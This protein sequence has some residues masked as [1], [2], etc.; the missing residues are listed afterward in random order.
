M[1]MRLFWWRLLILTHLTSVANA[2][3]RSVSEAFGAHKSR[4]AA[5]GQSVMQP[6]YNSQECGMQYD[7]KLVHN[8]LSAASYDMSYTH[9]WHSG[10][11]T[12]CDTLYRIIWTKLTYYC[13]ED[14][15]SLLHMLF[16]KPILFV[17]NE[18]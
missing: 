18:A 3:Y 14:S 16:C 12:Y 15:A 2:T 17:L 8:E 6:S 10:T 13:L 1:L 5:F 7:V 9:V 11:C 4:A